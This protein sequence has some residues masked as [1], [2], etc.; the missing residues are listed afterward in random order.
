MIMKCD[1]ENLRKCNK[2]FG[3]TMIFSTIILSPIYFYKSGL[4]QPAHV[5]MLISAVAL[6]FLNKSNCKDAIRKNLMGLY[7]LGLV[8][9]INFFYWLFYG[10]LDFLVSITYWLFGFL[11]LLSILCIARDEFILLWLPRLLVLKLLFIVIAYFSGFG[12]Y[13]WWPRYQY[14]FNG[15]NQLAYFAICMTLIV[16]AICRENLSRKI[17]L[18]YM[19]SCFIVISTG[20]RSAYIAFI[21]LV[22]MALWI[23]RKNFTG[24]AIFMATPFVILLIFKSFCLPLYMPMADGNHRIGCPVVGISEQDRKISDSTITRIDDLKNIKDSND[25]R[26]VRG[27]FLARGYT[28]ALEYPQYL[29]VGAGQGKEDRFAI[30]VGESYEIHSSLFAIFFYYGFIGLILFILFIAKLF[31]VKKNILFLTPLIVYG[32]FTYGLRS[33]YFWFAL[34]FLALMPDLFKSNKD[35]LNE[36]IR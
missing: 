34:G 10:D 2:F 16:M 12:S 20:G 29:L 19:L 21:P 8:F 17:Y 1:A 26:S 11:L 30:S 4:P 35:I 24:L 5:F 33:P 13:T 15:P 31:V 14:F 27:Q 23:A 36:S 32:L 9:A 28:R 25:N 7:F 6:L 3:F 22:M 18:V